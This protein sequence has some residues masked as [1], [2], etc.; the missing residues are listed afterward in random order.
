MRQYRNKRTGIVTCALCPITGPDWE[1][2]IPQAAPVDAAASA[3]V[4]PKAKTQP[5]KKP[6]SKA[7]PKKKVVKKTNG[8]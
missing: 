6:P 2:V 5:A 1:P 4:T 8:K 3:P 7:A